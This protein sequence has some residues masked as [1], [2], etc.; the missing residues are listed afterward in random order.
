ML[1]EFFVM[2]FEKL[3]GLWFWGFGIMVFVMCLIINI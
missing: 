2:K 1:V 3:L